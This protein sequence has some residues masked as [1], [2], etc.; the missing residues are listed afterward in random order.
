VE[1]QGQ[2]N[3]Y[4]GKRLFMENRIPVPEG[5]LAKTPEETKK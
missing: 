1:K 2:P 5:E 3:E 4:E